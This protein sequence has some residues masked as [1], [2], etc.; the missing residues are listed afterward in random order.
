M[1]KAN[2]ISHFGSQ[3]LTAAALRVKQPTVC[4]WPDDLPFSVL[5]RVAVYQPRAWRELNRKKKAAN[6]SGEQS[7]RSGENS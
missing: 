4:A 7:T 1:K 6:G 5:G 2:L 3:H